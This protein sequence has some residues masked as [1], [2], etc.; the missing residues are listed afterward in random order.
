MIAQNGWNRDLEGSVILDP[1]K[2]TPQVSKSKSNLDHNP[3]IHPPPG[4]VNPVISGIEPKWQ[5]TY[6]LC[7]ISK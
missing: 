1:K 3:L 5:T 6:Y 4:G 2:R 7:R